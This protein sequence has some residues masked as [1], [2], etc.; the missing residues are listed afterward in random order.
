MRSHLSAIQKRFENVTEKEHWERLKTLLFS[1]D[2]ENVVMGMNLLIKIDE[3]VYYDGICAFLEEDGEGNWKLKE[4]LGC[5]NELTLK[6]E[7][8]RLASSNI[9]HEIKEG[10]EDG[11]FD[12]ILLRAC[13]T[14][15]IGELS[16]HQKERLLSKVTEMVEIKGK[17]GHFWAMKYLVTQ[18]FWESVAGNNPSDFKG[19]S[20]PVEMVSWFD[21]LIFANKLSEREGLEKVYEIPKELI[22]GSSQSHDLAKKIKVNTS[23]N[24]YR[25][26]TEIEWDFSAR[27]GDNYIYAGS[28]NLDE[29]GWYRENSGYETHC[30]GQKK[31]NGYGLYD[32]TGNVFE[33][34]F[35]AYDSSLRILRGGGWFDYEYSFEVSY[36]DWY[37]PSNRYRDFGVRLFRSV[38]QDA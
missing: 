15:E 10:F 32:M 6:F 2:K 24:G 1:E 11:R 5:G 25:L 36:R 16:A 4:G 21:C 34:C 17:E 7:I 12:E 31:S 30:V 3:E 9:G 37:N 19:A 18:A 35:D 29:V 26:P 20:R 28:D 23:A 14:I 33:W 38:P 13:G 22:L 8:M 27:G